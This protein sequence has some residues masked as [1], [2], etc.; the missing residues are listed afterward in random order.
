MISVL[1]DNINLFR[2]KQEDSDVRGMGIMRFGWTST[3]LS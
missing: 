2:K 3:I 1:G